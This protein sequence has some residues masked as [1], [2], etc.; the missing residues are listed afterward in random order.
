MKKSLKYILAVILMITAAVCTLCACSNTPT[1]PQLPQLSSPE[2]INLEDNELYWDYVENSQGYIVS[3]KGDERL[4]D[5]T[6]Y[7]IPDFDYKEQTILVKAVGD[8]KNYSDSEWAEFVVGEQPTAALKYTLLSDGNGYEVSRL[9]SDVN[10]GLEGRVVIPDYYKGLP[11]IKIADS[12]F[13]RQVLNASTKN[14]VTTSIRLP[15]YLQSIGNHAFHRLVELEEV[16]IPESVTSIGKSAFA[17]CTKLS[18]INFPS[19]LTEIPEGMLAATAIT[20][21]EIPESVT[22][23]G[24]NAFANCQNLTQ[25]KIPQKE[26]EYFGLNVFDRTAWYNSQPD[27]LVIIRGD[28]LCGYKGG[29]P[30]GNI[31]IPQ[32]VKYVAASV[33]LNS[34][35]LIS[36][37]FPDQARLIGTSIFLNCD[38]LKEVK[39]PSSLTEIPAFTFAYCFNM[40]EIVIPKGVKKIGRVAFETH[41]KTVYYGGTQEEWD[42]IEIDDYR[43]EK[44]KSSTKYFYSENEPALNAEGTEYD[45][46]FWRYVDGKIVIWTK[47]N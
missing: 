2:N 24:D 39:L 1:P 12:A 27:G 33:F 31:I 10:K 46:N 19:E 40:E 8:G 18:K 15:A 38:S 45:G 3:V 28:I 4:T 13:S 44:L 7:F 23:I 20:Q 34:K 5:K 26:F 14:T 35:N 32:S 9:Y 37:T 22:S 25:I 16:Q 36:V 42:E 6:F 21:I 47:E 11:V 29:R 43:N 41:L 17:G 30:E